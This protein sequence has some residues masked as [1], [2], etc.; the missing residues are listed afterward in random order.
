MG[1]INC[2]LYLKSKG[3]TY[4]YDNTFFDS[5]GNKITFNNFYE[6]E[7]FCLTLKDKD[8]IVKHE[9]SETQ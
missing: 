2:I 9:R 4:I 8:G 6:L 3:Y 5:R 1:I 7:K